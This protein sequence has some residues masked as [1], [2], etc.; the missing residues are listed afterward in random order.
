MWG[1]AE[2]LRQ[3]PLSHTH[4]HLPLYTPALHSLHTHTHTPLTSHSIHINTH[5]AHTSHSTQTHL[6]CTHT[7]TPPTLHRQAQA[8]QEDIK[9]HRHLHHKNIV[10][11]YGAS[12][13]D[14]VLKIFLEFVPGGRLRVY[15]A[16]EFS[17]PYILLSFHAA[18]MD[19]HTY[20]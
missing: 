3:N 16:E 15:K 5:T 12:T 4:T 17:C 11:Y 8:T 2:R 20:S 14:G 1:I 19:M 18:F 7:H 9:L 6:H 10:Q 13:E